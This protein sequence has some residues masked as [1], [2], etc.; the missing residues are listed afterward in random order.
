MVAEKKIDLHGLRERD[1]LSK[2][3]RDYNT[4]VRSGWRDPIWVI[5]G[6]G[7]SGHGGVI[8]R[9]V[10]AY[11]SANLSRFEKVVEGESLANPGVTIVYPKR[12]L[13][14]PGAREW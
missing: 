4:C 11:I 7:S 6:Y 10:R 12:L 14:D 13:P 9:A 5:H 1:A 2:F 8:G 3:I